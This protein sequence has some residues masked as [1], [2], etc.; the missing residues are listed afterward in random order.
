VTNSVRKSLDVMVLVLLDADEVEVELPVVAF[1]AVEM[2]L[3]CGVLRA[4]ATRPDALCASIVLSTE[5]ISIV[6]SSQALK[7]LGHHVQPAAS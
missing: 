1:A 6:V 4:F 5:V 2:P 7:S 3:G